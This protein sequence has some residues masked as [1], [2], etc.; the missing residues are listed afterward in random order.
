MR[1]FARRLA[2]ESP[3]ADGMAVAFLLSGPLGVR[4]LVGQIGF[5]Q[6]LCYLPLAFAQAVAVQD[7][8]GARSVSRLALVLGLQ[9]LAG[10]PQMSWITWL[11]LAVFLFGRRLHGLSR[12]SL[13]LVGRD[14]G[15]LALTVAGGLAP[16]CRGAPAF[17]GARRGEQSHFAVGHLRVVV[18]PPGGGCRFAPPVSGAAGR[19]AGVPVGEQPL[20][21]RPR[22]AGRSV[23]PAH[24]PAAGRDG[25][26]A[27]RRRLASPGPRHPDSPVRPRL[28]GVARA[29]AVSGSRANGDPRAVCPAD[30]GGPVP[31]RAQ[32][33]RSSAVERRSPSRSWPAGP[34]SPC[35]PGSS[36]PR[37]SPGSPCTWA[38][39][40][41]PPWSSFGGPPAP[42]VR[43]VP[44]GP[45]SWPSSLLDLGTASWVWRSAIETARGAG[46][47]GPAR[48]GPPKSGVRA[49]RGE[50][51]RV[52]VPMGVARHNAGM[53]LGF[54]TPAGYVALSLDRVWTAIHEGIGVPLPL[55]NTFP[56]PE[57]FRQPFPYDSMDLVVGYD[58]PTQ[59]L[60]G[61]PP[62]DP[63]VY[64]VPC[65]RADRR[66]ARGGRAAWPPGTTSIAARS[67][68]TSYA[69]RGPLETRVGNGADPLLRARESGREDPTPRERRSWCSPKPGTPAGRL[70]RA[71]AS[72]C[73]PCRSTPGC[74]APS[75]PRDGTRWCSP[76]VPACCGRGRSC[77]W[78]CWCR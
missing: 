77:R 6:A 52:W 5:A 54:S 8:P 27:G 35:G 1:A 4:L 44:E 14:L 71:G 16:R 58:P 43:G 33:S 65:S 24:D 40:P 74:E 61:R 68:S 30:P 57:L 53:A 10:H 11:G 15:L 31:V 78:P 3:V 38:C 29:V 72:P 73:P 47:R 67:S 13:P 28:P 50:P 55:N 37:T 12:E 17:R 60:V 69:A 21:R 26:G 62:A 76:I 25:T 46:E 9:L 59:L 42:E 64:V 48:T 63:R 70:G 56:A 7:T 36:G 75:S 18:R 51:A 49:R 39:S 32:R 19:G 23:R 34:R 66:L 20:R 45:P 22:A 2:I 41:R